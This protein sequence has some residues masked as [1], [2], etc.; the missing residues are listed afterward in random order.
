MSHPCCRAFAVCF[1]FITW[2]GL[3]SPALGDTTAASAS[4][5]SRVEPEVYE[6][7]AE[8]DDG[9][10]YVLI[11]LLG[12]HPYPYTGVD[13]SQAI[14]SRQEM[15]LRDFEPGEFELAYRFRRIP[16]LTGR[17]T[18]AGLRRLDASESVVSVGLDATGTLSGVGAAAPRYHR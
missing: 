3:L 10:V 17:A 1:L 12:D 9:R 14:D 8:N 2:L 18:L 4:G 11:S 15:V 13:R 6:A 5:Q 16:G 7:L